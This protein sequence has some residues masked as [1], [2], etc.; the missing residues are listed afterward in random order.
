MPLRAVVLAIAMADDVGKHQVGFSMMLSPR[1][2]LCISIFSYPGYTHTYMYI[3]VY[4]SDEED[5]MPA[6]TVS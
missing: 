4:T 5:I 1:I 6:A 2:L 3:H